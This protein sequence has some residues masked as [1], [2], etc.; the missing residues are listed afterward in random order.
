MAASLSCLVAN[1]TTPT[2]A[3]LNGLRTISDPAPLTGRPATKLE[4]FM[5][6]YRYK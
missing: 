1:F 6:S 3:P 2:S 4:K 5:R